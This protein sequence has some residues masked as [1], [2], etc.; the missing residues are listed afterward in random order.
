MKVHLMTIDLDVVDHLINQVELSQEHFDKN[1]GIQKEKMIRHFGFL[2][3]I[4]F[5]YFIS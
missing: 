2:L 5:Y 4:D 3:S 1:P